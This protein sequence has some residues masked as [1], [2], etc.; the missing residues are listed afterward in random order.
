[1]FIEYFS[2]IK[3]YIN[4]CKFWVACKLFFCIL[5]TLGQSHI[6]KIEPRAGDVTHWLSTWLT[7]VRLS[8]VIKTSKHQQQELS[9]LV[10]WNNSRLDNKSWQKN[11]WPQNTKLVLLHDLCIWCTKPK[12]ALAAAAAPQVEMVCVQMDLSSLQTYKWTACTG[13]SDTRGIYFCFTAGPFLT[14]L[15]RT[16]GN[17]LW[18]DKEIKK[19]IKLNLQRTHKILRTIHKWT[20]ARM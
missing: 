3:L 10:F 16:I 13:G 18:P 17:S 9:H 2:W 7:S 4:K 20:T 12:I 19:N 1:M 6:L 5:I 8:S 14:S 11:G 15:Y